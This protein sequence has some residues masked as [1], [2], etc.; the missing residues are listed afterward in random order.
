MPRLPTLERG[1]RSAIADR[2]DPEASAD[3]IERGINRR[4]VTSELRAS[5]LLA[6]QRRRGDCRGGGE[7]IARFK[8]GA[9]QGQFFDLID[10]LQQHIDRSAQ[11]CR[12]SL[13]SDV[14]AH[15]SCTDPRNAN[16]RLS[17][18]WLV[19]MPR[20]DCSFSLAIGA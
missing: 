9:S 13:D 6:V 5:A 16:A 2:Q 1:S 12:I 8:T 7:E 18:P 20:V 4:E 19:A 11:P 15:G 10:E 17:S 3:A 14:V